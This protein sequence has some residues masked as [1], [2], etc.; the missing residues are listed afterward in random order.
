[1]DRKSLEILEFPQIR[2]ILAGFT[3]FSASRGLAS[4]LEP[5]VDPERITRLLEQSAEARN[6][7]S[8]DPG[9]SIGNATDIREMARLAS[10]GKILEPE[11]L[12]GIQQTLSSMYQL[13]RN[14]AGIADDFPRLWDIARGLVDLKHIARDIAGCLGPAGEVLDTASANLA[15][16]RQQL[17]ELR[18]Q[19]LERLEGIIGSPRGRKILQDNIITEREGR[20]VILV[21]M[22]CRHEIKG[23]VHDIS[24]TGETVFIEPSVTVGPGNAIR[25]L[26]IEERREIE[27]IL[28]K[29]SSE[30]GAY[31]PE[32]DR[33]IGLVAELDL[34]LAK[35]RY[36]RQVNAAEPDITVLEGGKGGDEP[37][38]TLRLVEARHPLLP[39][40]AVP[41]SV[42]IGRDFTVLLITGPNTGGKTVAL[43]TIGL[44]NLMA[45]AGI[46]IPAS[47]ESC[48]PVF[49]GIFADIG[50][51]QSIEQTLSTFSW[52]M[53]NMVRI[54][55]HTTGQS[56][57]LLDELGTSTDPAEGSALARSVLRHFLSRG[58]TTVATTHY[59]DLK[60][61]AHLTPGLENASL[62]FDPVTLS[63][64]YHLAVG[65]PG[66][67]NALA[68][69]SRLGIP[70]E[71][72]DEAR[73]MLAE[74]SQELE[75]LLT[76]LMAEKQ[77]SERLSRELA[78]EKA[79]LE[80]QNA[81]VSREWQQ[82]KA[83]ERKIIQEVRDRVSGEAAE[84]HKTIRQTAAELR[85]EQ[86]RKTLEQARKAMASIQE[87]LGS[88][89]WQVSAGGKAGPGESEIDERI[90]IGDTVW[91]REAN[92][93]ATVLSISE[94]AQQVEVQAGRTRMRLG[95]DSVAK[96]TS[97]PG[98]TTVEPAV[99]V[100]PMMGRAVPREYDLRGKRADEV[101]WAL[102]SYLNDAAR[103]NLSEVRIIHGM[104]TGT[105]RRIVRESVAAHPLVK[106]F[107]PGEKGEGGDGVTVV[108]L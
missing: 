23:I 75:T 80:Q 49:D 73:E 39:A 7:L 106:S 5:L 91:V 108:T 6:L 33:S 13:R 97:A 57:V 100:K 93:P 22:E 88:E 45:Q 76:S 79:K 59:S 40:N 30:M 54:I 15:H 37:V 107:R 105:V 24:N 64:T 66:G 44:L 9:F 95:L 58:I 46:P 18:K 101:E 27:R 21:K 78:G 1:M 92:L 20:Y 36:A 48:L 8:L 43:K 63:P 55:N 29:L 85:R 99:T 12:L 14:L 83:E 31:Y 65:I 89:A 32:I 52:H 102:D 68:T 84:L 25:E 103:A 77:K 51:E 90:N 70:P 19:L 26:A 96:V 69:A 60:A 94:P 10:L 3:S 16:I 81:E 28:G 72:I 35:A 50:D 74:G 104:A 61:F 38:G 42:E 71:I 87:Q 4:S 17:V 98:Q 47:P 56:L 41:L 67:S 11:D 2:E 34:A 86:S 62:E 82:L 53:G